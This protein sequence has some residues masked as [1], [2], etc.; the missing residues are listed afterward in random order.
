MHRPVRQI[1]AIPWRVSATY[2]NL[3]VSS[4]SRG[5]AERLIFC[6]KTTLKFPENV[7]LKR[8]TLSLSLSLFL[9]VEF[10][11]PTQAEEIYR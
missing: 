9:S 8:G 11:S 4:V 2:G 7:D 10:I 3:N 6:K 5:I 1:S